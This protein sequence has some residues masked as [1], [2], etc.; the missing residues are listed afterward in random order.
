V[1]GVA[2]E[3]SSPASRP[4]GKR[5]AGTPR[6]IWFTRLLLLVQGGILAIGTAIA[7][8]GL[9]PG[10]INEAAVVGAIVAMVP[11]CACFLVAIYLRRG[12]PVFATAAIVLEGIWIVLTG[13]LGMWP[14]GA[15]GAYGL[16]YLLLG[17]AS[18][19]AFIGLLCRPAR[20]F[21]SSIQDRAQPAPWLRQL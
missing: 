12:R 10:G 2:S 21:S 18:G 5:P 17:I 20:S 15:Q 7:L 3:D 6:A 14:S 13:L 11:A 16:Q 9:G 4:G 8:A 1:A 19:T